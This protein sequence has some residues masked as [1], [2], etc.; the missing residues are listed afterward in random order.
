M[1]NLIT[2]LLL[3][4]QVVRVNGRKPATRTSSRAKKSK[5]KYGQSTKG[6][7]EILDVVKE[8]AKGISTLI[9]TMKKKSTSS[10]MQKYQWIPMPNNSVNY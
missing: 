6:T 4:Q 7:S 9:D 10:L 2:I 5:W 3:F 8:S 1:N